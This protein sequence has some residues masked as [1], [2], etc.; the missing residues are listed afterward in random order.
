M[1]NAWH[2]QEFMYRPR[3]PQESDAT[4]DGN[5]VFSQGPHAIDILRLIG[6]GDGA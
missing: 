3:M 1:I 2:Y 5:A 6:G 4:K